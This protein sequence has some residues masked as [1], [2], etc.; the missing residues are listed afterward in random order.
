M[1][2]AMSNEARAENRQMQRKEHAEDKV[3][4]KAV[5]DLLVYLACTV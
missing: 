3:Q 4:L 5:N 2:N 1:H